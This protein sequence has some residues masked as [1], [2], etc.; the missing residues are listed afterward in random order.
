MRVGVLA[1]PTRYRLNSI[2]PLFDCDN[3]VDHRLQA[4]G[5]GLL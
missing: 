4:G 3:G 5:K 1:I 2:D